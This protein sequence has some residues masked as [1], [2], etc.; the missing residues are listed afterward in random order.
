MGEGGQIREA[1]HVAVRGQGSSAEGWY[2]AL[3]MQHS[4]A[5]THRLES[6][7][8]ERMAEAGRARVRVR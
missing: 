5:H 1:D 7:I 8:Y 6:A 4:M 3:I 2:R